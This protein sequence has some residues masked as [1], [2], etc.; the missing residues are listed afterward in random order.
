MS[1]HLAEA[2][3]LLAEAIGGDPGPEARLGVA[4]GWDSIAHMR[5]ILS[6]EA[7]IGRPLETEEILSL[8]TAEAIAAL[9]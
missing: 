4:K 5:L 6:L 1:G 8:E 3:A 2:Q 9:F 7:R